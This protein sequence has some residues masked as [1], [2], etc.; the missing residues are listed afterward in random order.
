MKPTL[1]SIIQPIFELVKGDTK[2]RVV[3][4]KNNT[5]VLLS[6]DQENYK[7]KLESFKILPTDQMVSPNIHFYRN[8]NTFLFVNPAFDD[9]G[10]L[11]IVDKKELNN[12]T[13]FKEA[14]LQNF[15]KDFLE[16]QVVFDSAIHNFQDYQPVMY[17]FVNNDLKMGGKACGQV[18]HA[19]GILVEELC[20]LPDQ[21]FVDWKESTM[22]KVVLKATEKQLEDLVKGKDETASFNNS[23]CVQV[24]DAGL[25]QIAA[26]SLTVVG[27]RPM[28]K[29][30]VPN[31]FAAYS[32]LQ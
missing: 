20:H 29:K 23:T 14:A 2:T 13:A 25:T 26:N 5:L 18:G 4:L 16:N 22:K 15:E 19:V 31:E 32:L 6:H 30:D 9:V 11:Y 7:D 27:F 21:C 10:L 17:L 28:Y 12:I 8:F 3:L 1:L 24:R